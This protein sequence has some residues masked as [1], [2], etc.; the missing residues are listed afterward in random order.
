MCKLLLERIH[1]KAFFEIICFSFHKKQ[2]S[3]IV[4]SFIIPV[5]SKIEISIYFYGPEGQLYLSNTQV[6]KMRRSRSCSA[7]VNVPALSQTIGIPVGVL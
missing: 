2:V 3:K 4:R 1:F 6:N 5:L 7:R